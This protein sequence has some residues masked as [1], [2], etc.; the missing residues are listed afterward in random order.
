MQN[1]PNSPFCQLCT[2]HND[3]ILFSWNTH[4]EQRRGFL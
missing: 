2:L 1:Q 3:T 4:K